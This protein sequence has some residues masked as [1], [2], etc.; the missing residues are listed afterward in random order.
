MKMMKAIIQIGNQLSAT[1]VMRALS[2]LIKGGPSALLKPLIW[3]IQNQTHKSSHHENHSLLSEQNLKTSAISELKVLFIVHI[4]FPEFVER[5]I[6]GAAQFK[7]TKWKF[8]VTSSNLEILEMVNNVGESQGLKEIYTMRVPNRGRNISPYIQALRKYGKDRDVVFH[9]HSKRSEHAKGKDVESWV[10]SQ[11]NLLFDDPELVKRVIALLTANTRIS[12]VY[13]SVESVISP[14]TYTWSSNARR[15]QKLL[16]P[17]GIRVNG[18]ERIAFPVGAMFAARTKDLLFLEK[19]QLEPGDFSEEAG[20]LDGELHHVVERLFGF[21][22]EKIGGLHA[23]YLPD[24]DAFTTE[25]KVLTENSEWSGF[26]SQ[27]GNNSKP[28]A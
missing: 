7:H 20:Q 18:S 28:I 27:A 5:F 8:V 26:T 12:I 3:F 16:L 2:L 4:F 10:N 19:L 1:K 23:I 25:T 14:W 17:L 9:V 11:W 24:S 21:V 13:P 15:A 6:R 22:P